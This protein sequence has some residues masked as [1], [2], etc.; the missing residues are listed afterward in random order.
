MGYVAHAELA[1]AVLPNAGGLGCI[2]SGSM[3][4]RELREQIRRCRALTDRPFAVDIL[5][6]EVKADNADSAV[7]Q[8]YT[9]NVQRAWT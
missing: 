6:A 3:G 9:G 8:R 2:G 5:F 7:V 1:A 4:S